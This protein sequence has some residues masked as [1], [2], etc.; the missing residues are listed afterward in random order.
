MCGVL[1]PQP[2]WLGGVPCGALRGVLWPGDSPADAGAALPALLH[3]DRVWR[4]G[5][6]GLHG[7]GDSAGRSRSHRRQPPGRH[8]FGDPVPDPG[9]PDGHGDAGSCAPGLFFGNLSRLL[10]HAGHGRG[11]CGGVDGDLRLRLGR[12]GEL[13]L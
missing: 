1:F 9:I 4:G 13:H 7:A 10:R 8:H 3:L 5:F 12:R 2:G 11:R 6:L